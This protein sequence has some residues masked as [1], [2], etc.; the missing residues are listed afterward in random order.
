[1][2]YPLVVFDWDGTLMDS[3]ARIVH[4]MQAAAEDVAIAVP[5]RA[6]ARDIIG[7]GMIEAVQQLFNAPTPA[8]TDAIIDR[9]R[10]HWLSDSL[11]PSAMF[12]GAQSL[13]ADLDQ[14]GY[15]LAVA[16][17]KSRRGLDRVLDETGLGHYFVASRCADEAFSKP[18]PQ[19]LLDILER[20]GMEPS[21][22]LM[23]GDTEYDM[24]MAAN[25]GAHAV[26]VSH[27]VHTPDR[28]RRSGAMTCLNHLSDLPNWLAQ[29]V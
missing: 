26:G 2:R 28:L 22:A 17:G 1:M 23:V 7:L 27:G 25:A 5:S 29:I 10:H 18:H 16:T 12:D 15:L 19:M 11:A 14:A 3:E 9:Y 4:C 13:L 6:A 21:Q 24:A 8:V 20:T